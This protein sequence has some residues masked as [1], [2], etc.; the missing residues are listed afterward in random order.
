[1]PLDHQIQTLSKIV[2]NQVNAL[3]A[4][5]EQPDSLHLSIVRRSIQRMVEIGTN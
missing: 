3:S 5:N 4:T 1:M 2:K